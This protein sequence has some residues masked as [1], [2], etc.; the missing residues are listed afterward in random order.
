MSLSRLHDAI[1]PYIYD[2]LDPDGNIREKPVEVDYQTTQSRGIKKAYMRNRAL[3]MFAD[4]SNFGDLVFQGALRPD[5]CFGDNYRF[6]HREDSDHDSF[7]KSRADFEQEHTHIIKG[8]TSPQTMGEKDLKCIFEHIKKFEKEIGVC[9]DEQTDCLLSKEDADAIVSQHAKYL[10]QQ[11]RVPRLTEAAEKLYSE[12]ETHC[13]TGAKTFAQAFIHTLM[14]KYIRPLMIT[15]GYKNATWAVEAAKSSITLLLSSSI[16]HTVL[17]SVIRNLLSS[18][19]T[20][21]GLNTNYIEKIVTEIGAIATFLNNPLSM[22]E[23]GVTGSAAAAGQAAAYQI[24]RNLPKLKVDPPV[25]VKGKHEA[26][27]VSRAAASEGLRR[28]KDT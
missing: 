21:L 23:W 2:Y 24:I 17:D 20:K 27:I 13:I 11:R 5:L 3:T 7:H 26:V 4:E 10:K 9:K 8:K 16:T 14:D 12:L 25:N 22:I 28:R 6:A 15:K 19:L 1:I 18:V